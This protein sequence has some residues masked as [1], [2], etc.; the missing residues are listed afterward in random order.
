MSKKDVKTFKL[1]QLFIEDSKDDLISLGKKR[2]K[3]Y[4]I[5][6][7]SDFKPVKRDVVKLIKATEDKMIPE[8]IDMRHQRMNQNVFSYYRATAGIM[9]GDLEKQVSTH[10]P[11]II[12]GDAHLTNFGFFASPERKLMFGLNDFDEAHVDNWEFDL[13]RLMTSVALI[14]RID[15]LKEEEISEIL[16]N[17]SH[18]YRR[19]IKYANSLQ[20][21]D[22]YYLSFKVDDLISQ[23]DPDS[24]MYKVLSKVASK[25]PKNNSDKVVKKFTELGPDGQLRFK[26]NPPRAR[27][28]S[29]KLYDQLSNGLREYQKTT[30]DDVRVLLVNYRLTDLIRYSVG[31]GSWGT[32]CYLA[33]LTGK[34]NSH[35]VL[36]IKEAMPLR[37]NMSVLS[38]N[39]SQDLE[40]GEG[41]RIIT[42]QRVLQ[43]FYDPFLGSMKANDRSFY[44]RQF[45]DMKDS[46][47]PLKL[48]KEGFEEYAYACAFILSI[49]HFQS[50]TAPMI[51]GYTHKQ[52]N[53]DTGMA[54][55]A[56]DYANQVQN[57]YVSFNNYL[58]GEVEDDQ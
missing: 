12:C 1:N 9:E 31:V 34:D 38:K 49:A 44:I 22:R 52:K 13:K 17:T 57:D 42:A 26:E 4:P 3:K 19:G 45:R 54:K 58:R 10:I 41:R 15:G 21:L 53:F 25:A 29:Q 23:A 43:T 20:L 6:E 51:Y 55:W 28:I 24:Q 33:L 27:H 46:I 32:R 2:R 37:Y 16:K 40:S 7:V 30:S 11:V 18:A 14:G 56:T 48:D 47:D 36:Q 5:E 35:L 8:L 39:E 50:P